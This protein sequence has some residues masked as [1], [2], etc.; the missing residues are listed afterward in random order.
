[1]LRQGCH[2]SSPSSPR[3]DAGSTFLAFVYSRRVL[4]LVK[5]EQSKRLLVQATHAPYSLARTDFAK[6]GDCFYRRHRGI[7][8]RGRS[9]GNVSERWGFGLI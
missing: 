1:M 7:I 4:L 3:Q 9:D 8:P 2:E 5:R 6:A